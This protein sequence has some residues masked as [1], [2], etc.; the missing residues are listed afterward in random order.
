[1]FKG[2]ISLHSCSVDGRIWAVLERD[3][4]CMIVSCVID[5]QHKIF[6]FRTFWSTSML[7][8]MKCGRSINV[9]LFLFRVSVGRST[10]PELQQFF[11]KWRRTTPRWS[12]FRGFGTPRH[13]DFSSI[14][15][16]LQLQSYLASGKAT[17]RHGRVRE[18]N[19]RGAESSS[20][21]KNINQSFR[22]RKR[23]MASFILESS[24]VY[25]LLHQRHSP[26]GR[27]HRDAVLRNM[28]NGC[29][30]IASHLIK[31]YEHITQELRHISFPCNPRHSFFSLDTGT[32]FNRN[33]SKTHS[34]P[35][36][37]N[38]RSYPD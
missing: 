10:T 7:Q 17:A 6:F 11:R 33:A 25:L 14:V 36:L 2:M 3:Q 27:Q 37:C 38:L 35:T 15:S 21:R 34:Q 23:V 9:W 32:S 20:Q 18:K 5:C 8:W 1:M 4:R 29:V 12:I 26:S 13:L 22:C 19:P 24:R 30:S 28:W 31:C 16:H